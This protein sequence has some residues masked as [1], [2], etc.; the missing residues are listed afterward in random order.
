MTAKFRVFR[1]R[2]TLPNDALIGDIAAYCARALLQQITAH[3]A[4]MEVTELRGYVRA[5]ALPII[6]GCAE[7]LLADQQTRTD[8]RHE[9]VATALERT[10]HLVIRDLQSPP[11]V[12]IPAPHL[13]RRAAA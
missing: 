9:I 13:P 6:R 2:A 10:I 12:A 1:R 11:V 7:Q 5:R 4:L 3:A 8:E